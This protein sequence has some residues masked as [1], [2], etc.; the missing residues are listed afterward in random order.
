MA[1][2]R[3]G[4]CWHLRNLDGWIA[5]ALAPCCVLAPCVA[6]RAVAD[7]RPGP[8]VQF[9]LRAVFAPGLQMFDEALQAIA[10]S[11]RR[12]EIQMAY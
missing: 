10:M 7:G 9:H 6:L 8:H 11:C 5:G 3:A 12:V 1:Q 4:Q 2:V